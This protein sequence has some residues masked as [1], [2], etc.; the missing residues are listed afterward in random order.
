MI[1]ELNSSI[2]VNITVS[3]LQSPMKWDPLV[4]TFQGFIVFV[5]AAS[6]YQLKGPIPILPE[7]IHPVFKSL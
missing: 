1:S 7:G 6:Q 5:H 3:W 4:V 2:R